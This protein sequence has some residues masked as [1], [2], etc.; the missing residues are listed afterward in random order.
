MHLGQERM[1]LFTTRLGRLGD[2]WSINL[3]RDYESP[4]EGAKCAKTLVIHK[5]SH[6][7]Q[8]A[9][10]RHPDSGKNSSLALNNNAFAE[11]VTLLD[12][13]QSFHFRMRN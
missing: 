7:L 9:T 8:R 5:L 3:Q 1:P 13:R 11:I 4:G 6:T 2:H 12:S 10:T